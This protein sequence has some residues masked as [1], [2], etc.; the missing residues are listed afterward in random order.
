MAKVALQRH[1]KDLGLK[2]RS[3]KI[4]M[5]PMTDKEFKY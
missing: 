3:D 1:K 2:T 5:F 4:K